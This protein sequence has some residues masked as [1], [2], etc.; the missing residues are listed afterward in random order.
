MYL[1]SFGLDNLAVRLPLQS[2]RVTR[3]EPRRHVLGSLLDRR[4][5]RLS[6]VIMLMGSEYKVLTFQLHFDYVKKDFSAHWTFSLFGGVG[7]P[8]GVR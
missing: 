1:F 8:S 3:M 6:V 5:T 4:E 7:D 2:R